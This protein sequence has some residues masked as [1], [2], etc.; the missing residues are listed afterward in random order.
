ML[1]SMCY[2]LFTRNATHHSTKAIRTQDNDV[3]SWA[4]S[5]QLT[6][7]SYVATP[8]LPRTSSW[9]S[10]HDASKNEVSGSLSGL[11]DAKESPPYTHSYVKEGS[12]ITY[13]TIWHGLLPSRYPSILEQ[14]TV[15]IL[16]G[17]FDSHYPVWN[18][19]SLSS[20]EQGWLEL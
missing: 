3:G 20:K 2:R 7:R 10:L 14:N 15:S 12:E 4:Y 8:S 5:K 11:T 9:P 16:K 13:A 19:L 1:G 17:R 6:S 18:H